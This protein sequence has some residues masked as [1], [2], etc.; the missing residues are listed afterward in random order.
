MSD[1]VYDVMGFLG[2]CVMAASLVPQVYRVTVRK[3][4]ADI[5]HT[6]QVVFVT[7]IVMFLVF[8]GYY[9]LWELFFPALAS[10]MLQI[11]LAVLKIRLERCPR[12][13]T[14]A[15]PSTVASETPGEG[16]TLDNG[17]SE[18]TPLLKSV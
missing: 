9:E 14:A 2:G 13:H 10:M 11:Y 6:Y 18:R 8:Y 15:A 17:S 7:G 16:A 12:R 5:S 3:K 4:A 1:T